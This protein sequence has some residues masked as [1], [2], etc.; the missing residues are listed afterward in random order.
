LQNLDGILIHKNT[1][2]FT[3]PSTGT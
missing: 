2:F 1:E 3:K